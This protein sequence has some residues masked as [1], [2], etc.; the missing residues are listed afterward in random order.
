MPLLVLASEQSAKKKNIY[1]MIIVSW[2]TSNHFV[3]FSELVNLPY[4][5][6]SQYASGDF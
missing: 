4:G 6:S 3:L 5:K 2:D 1:Q